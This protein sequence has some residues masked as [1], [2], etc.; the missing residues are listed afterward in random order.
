M[1][2]EFFACGIEVLFHC[3]QWK[4]RKL[5]DVCDCVVHDVVIMFNKNS[6]L[7]GDVLFV[8]CLEL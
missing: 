7:V 6:E 8:V 4:I 3:C 5:F 1:S 2:R